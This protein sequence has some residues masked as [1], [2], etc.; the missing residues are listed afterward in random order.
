VTNSN[1]LSNIGQNAHSNRYRD[2]NGKKST[3][4]ALTGQL[5]HLRL[6]VK[7]TL[8]KILMNLFDSYAFKIFF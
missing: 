1:H 6:N 5:A 4:I 3:L 2:V 8:V 7:K